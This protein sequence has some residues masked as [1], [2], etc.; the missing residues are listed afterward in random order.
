MPVSVM[1][2][3]AV[4]EGIATAVAV[5][6]DRHV[7]DELALIQHSSCTAVIYSWYVGYDH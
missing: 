2:H 6:W 3:S 4:V 5:L 7:L 1:R